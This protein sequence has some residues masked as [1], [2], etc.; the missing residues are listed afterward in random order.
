VSYD[1]EGNSTTSE[2]ENPT[3]TKDNEERAE[4]Q[5]IVDA[6][7]QPVIDAYNAL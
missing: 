6:T 4:A 1:E 7:P 3:I 2:I 5:A